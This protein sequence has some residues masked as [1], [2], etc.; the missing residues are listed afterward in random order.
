MFIF[1]NP[2]LKRL[3][4][5]L[6]RQLIRNLQSLERRQ[7]KSGALNLENIIR[8]III[9][10]QYKRSCCRKQLPI[11]STI[12]E[13]TFFAMIKGVLAPQQIFILHCSERLWSMGIREGAK[14]LQENALFLVT[15]YRRPHWNNG[16]YIVCRDNGILT[17][18]NL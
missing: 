18:N 4:L 15:I 6:N 7:M 11:I 12:G 16:S 13:C 3:L 5:K 10:I 8:Y 14:C 2:I 9:Y 17:F 1:H